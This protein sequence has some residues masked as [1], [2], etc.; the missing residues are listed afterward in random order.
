MPYKLCQKKA[1]LISQ[2]TN[3]FDLKNKEKIRQVQIADPFRF[4]KSP[5]REKNSVLDVS[6]F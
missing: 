4:A 2:N 1:Y 5:D 6:N 3:V